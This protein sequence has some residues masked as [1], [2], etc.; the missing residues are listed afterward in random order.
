MGNTV[1]TSPT[2]AEREMADGL[3][4]VVHPSFQMA[5]AMSLY[6]PSAK[7]STYTG[8]YM[9]DEI[10]RE[11]SRRMHYA[12]WRLSREKNANKR[13]MW[14]QHYLSMR[15]LVVLGNRKLV[16]R[17][18]R[19]WLSHP[20]KAD[21]LTSDCQIVMIQ[22]VAAYNPWLGIRFSTYAYTC[23]MRA[24]SRMSLKAKGDRMSRSVPLEGIMVGEES[25]ATAS[26]PGLRHQQT[27]EEFLR[28]ECDLLTDRERQVIVSRFRM[29]AG[30]AEATLDQVG[31]KL[32]L[33]KERVRQVQASALD[34]LRQALSRPE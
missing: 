15:D 21:D 30:Q 1:T 8:S 11:C 24:L 14:K 25:P 9:P 32:G 12:A 13:A 5:G 29:G 33:S 20:S 26:D 3:Y 7:T 31:K 34:K 27:V 2:K 16:F 28:P 10:T 19:R 22:S 6:G 23:L 18:V 17:A 4:F